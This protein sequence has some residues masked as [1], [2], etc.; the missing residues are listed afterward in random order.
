MKLFCLF[1][2]IACSVFVKC[3]DE[4]MTPEPRDPERE[5]ADL[6]LAKT[7]ATKFA[8]DLMNVRK[9]EDI[10]DLTNNL[11]DTLVFNM[12]E[13]RLYKGHFV[14]FSTHALIEEEKYPDALTL[15][16]QAAYT[17]DE[18]LSM[19]VKANGFVFDK[20]DELIL[21]F[22]KQE[23]GSYKLSQGTILTCRYE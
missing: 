17:R 22:K 6:A 12:C 8:A 5:A 3:D 23:D 15:E 9:S 14:A 19:H 21:D 20:D 2:L 7:V 10:H 18:N 16:P 11:M 4:I 1:I 13:N